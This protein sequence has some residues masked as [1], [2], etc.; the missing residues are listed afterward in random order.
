VT[1]LCQLCSALLP[2]KTTTW[3]SLPPQQALYYYSHTWLTPGLPAV[4]K[5]R[6]SQLGAGFFTAYLKSAVPQK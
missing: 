3:A 1:A 2:N 4:H 5:H 6:K